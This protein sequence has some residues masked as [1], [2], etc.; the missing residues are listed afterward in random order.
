MAS[1]FPVAAANLVLAWASIQH[2]GSL[3]QH[4]LKKTYH[5]GTLEKELVSLHYKNYKF[6]LM[7]DF[8]ISPGV[9]HYI[10]LL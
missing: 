5:I 8:K 1:G 7:K 6:L 2:F 3:S 10:P 9:F 4:T